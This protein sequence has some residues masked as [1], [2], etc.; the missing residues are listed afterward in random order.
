MKKVLAIAPYSYLPYFSGGQKFIAKFYEYLGREVDLTVI[1]VA[2]NDAAL[3]TYKII[4]LLKAGFSRYYDLSLTAKL[5]ELINKEKYDAIIWEH[6]YYGWLA[7]K[8]KKRTGIKTIIHTHNIEYQRFRSVGKWWWPVLRTYERKCLQRADGILFIT[9]EDRDFAVSKWNIKKE[10]TIIVPFGVDID[11]Y[12]PD[13]MESKNAICQ[14]HGI[15]DDEKI[16][17]FNGLLNYKPN[18]DAINIILKEI[19]PRL[20]RQDIKFKIIICG[21]GLP[22]ELSELKEYAGKNII[23]AG[24]VDDIETYFKAADVFLNPVQSGGG[25]KTKMVEAIAFNATVVSTQAGAAGMDRNISGPKLVV[26][27]DNDWS[28]FVEE[29]LRVAKEPSQPTPTAYYKEYGWTNII[30]RLMTTIL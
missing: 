10:N 9:P 30:D 29:I 27:N 25:I 19:N 5:A 11:H 13:K 24:F 20:L 23:Y 26:V 21:K 28:A 6:P 1:S 3:A 16:I 17:L 18:L 4:P 7:K 22:Q 8:I 15:G 14:K 2:N 12:P